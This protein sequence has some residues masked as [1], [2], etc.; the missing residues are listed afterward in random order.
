LLR[1]VGEGVVGGHE[2]ASE[3]ELEL[4]LVHLLVHFLEEHT[5]EAQYL[6]PKKIPVNRCE[7]ETWLNTWLGIRTLA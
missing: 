6:S 2:G 1:A 4:V 3:Q 5:D 7:G